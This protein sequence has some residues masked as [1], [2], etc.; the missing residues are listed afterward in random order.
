MTGG[1]AIVLGPTGLNFGAGM[2][3]GVAWIYDADSSFISKG[4]FHPDFIEPQPFATLEA[5]VQESLRSLI[6]EH[7]ALTDSG[8]AKTLLGDW[9][10]VSQSFVR[11]MPKPQA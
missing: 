5:E 6:E 11:L 3:G 1:T 10:K 8:L 9:Q 2:T 7:V 4:R